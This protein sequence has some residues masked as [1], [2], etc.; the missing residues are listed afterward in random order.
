MSNVLIVDDEPSI[1]WGLSRL[2][3]DEGHQPRTASCAEEALELLHRCRFD[4][5]F[6]DVRLPGADGF[7]ILPALAELADRPRVVVMTAFGDLQTAVNAYRAGACDYLTKPFGV[8]AVSRALRRALRSSCASTEC[9][10]SQSAEDA[11]LLLGASPLMQEVFKRIAIVAPTQMS[12]L[13]RGESGTGKELVAQ[14]IHRHSPRSDRPFVAIHLASL[15]RSVIESEL[16]G[17]RRGAYTG[18]EESKPGL[19]EVANGGTVFLDEIGEVSLDVQVKLLRAIEQREIIAVGDTRPRHTDIRVIAATNRDLVT[20]MAQ[21]RFR[22][23]LYF[24]LAMFEIALPPLRERAADVPL[25]AQHFLRGAAESGGGGFTD[26]ALEK[27][28]AYHWPGNV[29]Q[30]KSVVQAAAV[31]ARGAPIEPEHLQFDRIHQRVGQHHELAEVVEAWTR[32]RLSSGPAE[33]LYEEFLGAVEKPFFKVVLEKT[34]Q[35]RAAAAELLGI[36]R[37]TLRKKLSG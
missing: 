35:N 6:L 24:R 26:A 2:V 1:A 34:G 7:S 13:L 11:S 30:L 21:G 20:E 29:R 9:D 14:A 37:A 28:A 31:L 23:D 17:H 32:D 8:D 25:L 16:F 19:L 27:L 15:S 18:A 33:N 3:R 22:E 5:V 12:V 36:H 10:S 4:V